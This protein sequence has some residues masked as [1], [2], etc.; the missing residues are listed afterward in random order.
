MRH[1]ARNVFVIGMGPGGFGHLTLDA[2]EAM[3]SVDVFLVADSATDQAD[4]VWLRSEL[5]R[6]HVRRQHRVITVLDRPDGGAVDDLDQATL[7]TYSAI[8]S[9]LDDDACVGFLSWGDPA[10]YDSILRIVDALSSRLPLR[11]T[12]I[13]GVSAPQVLAAAHRIPLNRTDGSVSFVSGPRLLKDFDPALGDVVVLNDTELACRGLVAEFPE[14]EVFW[15][16]YLGTPDQVLANGP[17]CQVIDDLLR[18]REQLVAHHGWIQDTYL[19]R[20]QS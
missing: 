13:P 7:E 9:G 20:V 3:N 1:V 15:G 6:R 19:L 11:V 16:A 17:L 2:V 14:I 18:L 12:V 8:I 10:L 4:L 5:L